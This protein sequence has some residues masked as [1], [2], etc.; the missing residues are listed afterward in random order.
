MNGESQRRVQSINRQHLNETIR[1]L[2]KP[3]NVPMTQSIHNGASSSLS[4]HGIPLSQ[5]THQ[6]R[7]PTP[8]VTTNNHLTPTP[9]SSNT[10]RVS[11]I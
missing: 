7:A 6:F 2:S 11:P 10:R 1:R 9:T 4:S 8:P 3:K 5:S